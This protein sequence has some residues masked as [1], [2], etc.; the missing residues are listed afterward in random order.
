[1]EDFLTAVKTV[2]KNTADEQAEPALKEISS[3]PARKDVEQTVAT[4]SSKGDE[5]SSATKRTSESCDTPEKAL[6]LLK[7]EPDPDSLIRTLRN[8]R[9]KEGFSANFD[10][11]IPGPLQAQIIGSIVGRIVPTFWHAFTEKN[12]DLIASCL[13]SVAGANAVVARMRLLCDSQTTST[14]IVELRDLLQVLESIFA[15]DDFVHTIWSGLSRASTNDTQRSMLWKEF[16]NL[17]GSGKII[18]TAARSEDVLKGDDT[19]AK[20][21]WL[22]NGPGFS[23]WLGR[24]IAHLLM[25]TRRD[26]HVVPA[27]DKFAA[28]LLAKSLSLG[29]PVP[30]V[31]ELFIQFIRRISHGEDGNASFCGLVRLL[32]SYGKRQLI[33]NTLRWL[34]TVYDPECERRAEELSKSK[35]AV[36]AQAALISSLC[37]SDASLKQLLIEFLGDC[38]LLTAMT[39]ELRRACIVVLSSIAADDLQPLLEKLMTTFG[40]TLFINHTPI[41]QQEAMA[42]VIVLTAGYLHRTTPIAVLMTARSSSHMQGVSSRLDSTN[43]KARW[44]GM[45]CGTAFSSLVDKGGSKMSFGTEDMQTNEAKWY[46][47]LVNIK[48]EVGR[49]EDLEKLVKLQEVPQIRKKRIQQRAPT[50]RLPVVDGKQTFGPLR[51][52]APAQ[53]EV[54]GEKIAEIFDDGEDD[55]EDEDL[56]PHAKPDSDPEDSDEDATLVNRNK[57]RAPVYIR[58]LMRMLKDDQNHDRF[59]MGIRHAS[60]LI[61]RKTHF[62]GEVKDHAEE[63]ALILCDLQDPF[64]TDDFDELKLQALIAILLS[65]VDTMAPWLSKQAFFGDYSLSQRCIMLSALGLGGRELAGFKDQ[66]SLNP[67]LPSSATSFPSRRLPSHLH[68]IYSPTNASV[69]RLEAASKNVEHQMMKPLALSAADKTTSHLDAVKVRTFSSRMAVERTKRKPAP[70]QLAKILGSGFFFPLLSRYQ[71]EISAYGQS[72]VF[73]SASFLLVTFLKTL[74]LLLH[75]SGPATMDLAEITA[76]FW[77]LLLSLRVQAISDI[78]VLQAVLFALL[79]LLEVNSDAKQRIVQE[80]PKQLMETQQW[81]DLVFERT[82]GGALITE[83]SE[84][85]TRVRTLSA[86]VLVKTREIIEAYQKSLTGFAYG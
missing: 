63:I 1:M 45:I 33:E 19:V 60:A 11:R 40:G 82:G 14:N 46:L 72:S 10:I 69:K 86:G 79:T 16:V 35:P 36:S 20:P 3:Q 50:K 66:D 23:A 29:Y 73:A 12:R 58:D 80:T 27:A 42:Q 62:G 70:N 64:Q 65:D 15:G 83:G 61:R 5:G 54:I 25:E 4:S 84:D 7:S 32:P 56:K 68:A 41:L 49:L 67:T 53:T 43:S 85:E 26:D 13:R 47:E 8:L 44:L 78:S 18:S 59:Q 71:Q 75:A 57:S 37:A 22:S 30:L 77:D 9:S 31:K 48:D 21:M 24:N 2:H 38:T 55:D 81:V 74:A 52:P 39:F 28:E 17:V 76:A 6:Q 51:P 34:S